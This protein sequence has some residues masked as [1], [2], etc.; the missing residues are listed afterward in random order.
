MEDG[1]AEGKWEKMIE[2]ILGEDGEGKEWL[3]KLEMFREGEREESV[4]EGEGDGNR[5]CE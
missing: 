4:E 1:G 2:K 5:V 3:R